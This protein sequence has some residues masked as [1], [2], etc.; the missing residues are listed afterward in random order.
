MIV[1]VEDLTRRLVEVGASRR[2]VGVHGVGDVDEELPGGLSFSS[3]LDV[4]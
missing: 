1:R 2:L 4:V 3:V